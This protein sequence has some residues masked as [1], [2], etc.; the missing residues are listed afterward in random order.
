MLLDSQNKEERFAEEEQK[1]E[2]IAKDSL[3]NYAMLFGGRLQ[4]QHVKSGKYLTIESHAIAEKDR[5]CMGLSLTSGSPSSYFTITPVYRIQ[6][7]V[8]IVVG[9]IARRS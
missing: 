7:E 6:S 4:L 1:N 8:C 3:G 2:S 9:V 5:E